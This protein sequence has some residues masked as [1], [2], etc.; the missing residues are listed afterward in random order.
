MRVLISGG[1]GSGCTS[2]AERIGK[3]LSIPVFDSDSFFHKPSEPPFQE[4]YSPEETREML[5]SALSKVS[6]WIVS[7]SVAT[8]GLNAFKPTHGVLLNV[9]KAVR[10]QRLVKRQ[11]DQFGP[12]IDV[13]GD[14]HEE[15]EAFIEWA[16]GY[17]ERPGIGRNLATDREFLL[18]HSNQFMSIDKVA[19]MDVIVGEIVSFL[20]G[21]IVGTT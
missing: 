8:W 10:L 15:H 3:E 20:S 2:T 9:R 12:R 1:P 13:G 6:S 19:D 5:G 14:M 7:G 16:A 17:E 21:T 11:R 18:N 4:Q